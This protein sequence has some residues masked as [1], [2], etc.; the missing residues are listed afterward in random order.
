MFS[1]IFHNQSMISLV[2][3]CWISYE[4]HIEIFVRNT[5]PIWCNALIIFNVCSS[6]HRLHD[7]VNLVDS[8]G[9]CFKQGTVF[10]AI[11]VYGQEEGRV[12]SECFCWSLAA[13][14]FIKK[15]WIP[16]RLIRYSISTFWPVLVFVNLADE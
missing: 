6:L 16:F 8:H 11:V 3:L 2:N 1:L 10:T 4:C 13:V 9:V 7:A 5:I 15:D 12:I 14:D